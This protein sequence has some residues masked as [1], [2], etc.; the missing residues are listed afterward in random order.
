VSAVRARTLLV[1]V[2]LATGLAAAA[3]VGPAERAECQGL[4]PAIDCWSDADC[5]NPA[6]ACVGEP[7][8]AGRCVEAKPQKEPR[9]STLPG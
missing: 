6:C 2:A 9:G 8:E 5:G 4:C 3:L 1:A 7:G